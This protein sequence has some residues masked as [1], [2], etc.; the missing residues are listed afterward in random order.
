[1]KNGIALENIMSSS[2]LVFGFLFVGLFSLLTAC[3][4]AE[5]EQPTSQTQSWGSWSTTVGGTLRSADLRSLSSSNFVEASFVYVGLPVG[6]G[7][8]HEF[9]GVEIISQ[10][11]NGQQSQLFTTGLTDPEQDD[12]YFRDTYHSGGR[13]ARVIRSF[14]SYPNFNSLVSTINRAMIDSPYNN[15]AYY[16]AAMA[17]TPLT[18]R[19]CANVARRIEKMVANR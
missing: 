5:N 10:V 9:I 17:T 18:G 14:T 16:A 19:P 4:T 13:R 1:M 2:R 15:S 7:I 3:G 8:V 6:L 12:P 11:G